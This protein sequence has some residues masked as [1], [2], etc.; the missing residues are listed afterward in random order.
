MEENMSNEKDVAE[1]FKQI[2]ATIQ[3]LISLDVALRYNIFPL[4]LENEKLKVAMTNPLDLNILNDLSFISGYKIEPIEYPEKSILNAI[5]KYYKTDGSQ[6]KTQQGEKLKITTNHNKIS[7]SEN[8]NRYI[9]LGENVNEVSIIQLVNQFISNAINKRA[10]DI[11][12]EPYEY[13]FRVRFRIDGILQEIMN[14]PLDKK[15]AVISRLKIMADLDIAEKR[16]PQDGRIR[17]TEG[18]KQIDIRLSTI[19]TNFGEK[20]VLRILDQT[21]INL[22]LEQLGFKT[23]EIEIFCQAIT[24]PFGMCLVTGPTGS[25]KTTTLYAALNYL[26]TQER[27][28]LTIEDPIEYNLPGINQSH[29]RSEIGYTFAQALRAFLRQDPNIIMVG[30]IRDRETSEI[31]IR[32]ALTGHLVLSTLHTNDAAT[33][34][35]RLID[36]GLEPFLISSSLRLVIAQ[37]LVRKI[38]SYCLSEIKTTEMTKTKFWNN[39]GGVNKIPGKIFRGVGC[40]KCNFTGY[41]GRT[42]LLELMPISPVIAEMI[43]KKKTAFELKQQAINEGMCTLRECGIQK[44]KDG[45]TTVDEVI[46]ETMI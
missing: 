29:V 6:L 12:I 43:I 45:V 21:A 18:E 24:T 3:K 44:I 7:Q 9:D 38:C 8:K 41:K 25:G 36:M 34:I 23:K 5:E 20:I 32:A 28:I 26:N 37:R 39:E 1:D 30:E 13:A 46:R 40:E 42:A 11:H 31:A 15:N 27:N 33:E 35:S 17:T 19:P 10:S 16:R 2:D 22:D 4:S 14:L